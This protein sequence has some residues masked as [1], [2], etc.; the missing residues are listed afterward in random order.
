MDT[1]PGNVF[2]GQPNEIGQIHGTEAKDTI[3]GTDKAD[4]IYGYAGADVIYGGA[5]DDIIY[6]GENGDTLYGQEG[7]DTLYGGN[8]ND[9]LN[10]GAG[11][12]IM[13]GG[14]GNDVYM[15]EQ[16][17]DC[18][19]EYADEGIDTVRTY[20]DYEL[21]DNVENLILMGS[22]DLNGTGNCLDNEIIGNGGNNELRGM[23]GNDRLIGKGGNDWLDGGEGNDYLEGGAG[24]DT[25]IFNKGYGHDIICDYDTTEG[26]HDVIEFWHGLQASDLSFARTGNDLT[27]TAN[28]EDSLTVVNWFES[29]AYRIEEFNFDDGTVWDSTA[30]DNVL[31]SYGIDTSY[32]AASQEQIA[33]QTQT[34]GII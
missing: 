31:N 28:S 24:N 30:I 15:V 10:G 19:I 18:V 9:Y 4:E 26:N 6:G 1:N 13:Y 17:G 7:N 5:G 8:G 25:Y 22:A 12:D 20:I 27:I 21:P 3:Y 33:Q 23:D 16:P 29:A 32:A 34:Q 14:A 11:D 2:Q